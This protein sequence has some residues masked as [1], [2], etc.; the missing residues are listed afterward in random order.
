MFF[1]LHIRDTI[2][3]PS[4]S[5]KFV[6]NDPLGCLRAEIN[7][8]YANK[9]LPN[10]G[11]VISLHSVLSHNAPQ[12]FAGDG[13]VYIRASFRLV[14][15]RPFEGEILVGKVKQSTKEGIMV[16]L[17]FFDHIRIP[18]E[19]MPSPSR[20]D[21]EEGVWI[22]DYD[23][24][25]MFLDL[26]QFIRIRV[27]QV[28]FS[29]FNARAN[30]TAEPSVKLSNGQEIISVEQKAKDRGYLLTADPKDE[31]AK[32]QGDFMRANPNK[33]QIGEKSDIESSSMPSSYVP[34]LDI[35]ASINSSGLGLLD[36]W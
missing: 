19:C 30:S 22:W 24:N 2:R 21:E 17:G 33:L 9:V 27:Q 8:K 16:S 28:H 15:F 29:A 20:F 26:E 18:P 12:I 5:L 35:K 31:P 11:L 23:G 14:I 1:L 34:P 25:D 6:Q 36:W 7:A 10:Q 3:V 32:L 13:G 4:T